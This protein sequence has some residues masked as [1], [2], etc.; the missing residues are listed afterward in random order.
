M[1]VFLDTEFTNLLCPQLLS[2]GMVTLDGREFYAEIDLNT[3][4][5]K[6][7]VKA[8]SDFVRNGDVLAQWG[9]VANAT[10]TEWE[11]GRR[12]GEWLLELA[13]EAG[14]K[15]EIAF[16]YSDDY[17]LLEAAIRLSG[18]WDRVRLVTVPVNVN[19]FTGCIA[20]KLAAEAC[21]RELAEHGGRG[22]RRHHALADAMVLRAAYLAVKGA[23]QA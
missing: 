15:L 9:L 3:D 8:S 13:L 6:H 5:G 22:L 11:I 17:E 20:G 19:A 1:L 18:L 21:F 2:V 7:R 23:A 4:C 16:D 10:G 12:A 14:K